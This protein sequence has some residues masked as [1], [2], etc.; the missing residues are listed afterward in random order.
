[1]LY[2]GVQVVV[3]IDIDRHHAL[4]YLPDTCSVLA[5]VPLP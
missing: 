5:D 3:A 2:K 1:V 4:A